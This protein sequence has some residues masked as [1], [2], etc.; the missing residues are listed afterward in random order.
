PLTLCSSRP[1]GRAAYLDGALPPTGGSSLANRRD[2][3]A[4][5]HGLV[6]REGSRFPSGVHIPK[7]QGR[8]GARGGQ[9]FAVGEECNSKGPAC[10]ARKC[11]H[12]SASRN[13]P[14]SQGSVTMGRGQ[15]FAVRRKRNRVDQS[16]PPCP[17]SCG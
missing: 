15:Q 1:T 13:V 2:G 10:M 4:F 5:S 16:V 11:P 17:W 14:Q 8:I 3:Q 7:L 9:G 6:S 12:A